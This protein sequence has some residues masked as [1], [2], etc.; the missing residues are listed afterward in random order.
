M[1][2]CWLLKCQDKPAWKLEET[3]N[4]YAIILSFIDHSKPKV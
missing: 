3:Q 4:A 1:C 2:L